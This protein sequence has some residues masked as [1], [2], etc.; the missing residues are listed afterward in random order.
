MVS[1]YLNGEYGALETIGPKL[2]SM[3]YAIDRFDAK[4]ETINALKECDYVIANRYVSSNMIFQAAKLDSYEA[5]D[6]YLAWNYDLEFS[7]FGIP[8]PTD[9]LFLNISVETSV[10]LVAMKEQRDYI[11]GGKTVDIH[12][13]DHSYLRRTVNVAHYVASKYTN[14]TIIECEENGAMLP[15]ESITAKILK[16]IL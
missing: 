4:T 11:K 9:V 1:K 16:K 3:F 10:R 7:V 8:K 15:L 13:S 2:G 12:E 5:I 6:E 14:W